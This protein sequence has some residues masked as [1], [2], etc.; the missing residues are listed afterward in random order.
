[1]SI[2]VGPWVGKAFAHFIDGLARHVL[3]RTG[4][5]AQ[6][7][8]GYR[9]MEDAAYCTVELMI[10][11]DDV[12]AVGLVPGPA[13]GRG[14]IIMEDLLFGQADYGVADSIC[15]VEPGFFLNYLAIRDING[16]SHKRR[17]NVSREARFNIVDGRRIGFSTDWANHVASDRQ[18]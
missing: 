7:G 3:K 5:R 1:M 13:L 11:V 2:L 12:N 6:R 14:K 10:A 9:R 16:V 15:D 18:R 17:G 8:K 4:Q